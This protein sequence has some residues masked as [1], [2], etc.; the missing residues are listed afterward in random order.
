[1]E[2]KSFKNWLSSLEWGSIHWGEKGKCKLRAPKSR[3]WKSV[4]AGKGLI[5][6][7][8]FSRSIQALFLSPFVVICIISMSL[9]CLKFVS[10]LEYTGCYVLG[11]HRNT[12]THESLEII[13]TTL[14]SL[15]LLFQRWEV[16][17]F[18]YIFPLIPEVLFNCKNTYFV[19]HLFVTGHCFLFKFTGSVHIRFCL[20]LPVGL[21]WYQFHCSIF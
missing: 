3:C 17:M 12:F 16:S 1:M 6:F 7:W 13:F 15:P 10:S 9:P 2:T 19:F 4:G 20:V 11:K 8:L 18:C 21:F 14:A 5:I